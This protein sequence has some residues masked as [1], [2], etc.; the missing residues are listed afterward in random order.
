MVKQKQRLSGPNYCSQTIFYGNKLFIRIGI[1]LK[2]YQKNKRKQKPTKIYLV[3][4]MI[5]TNSGNKEAPPTKKPSILGQV[6]N[7]L[8]LLALTEPP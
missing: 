8:A 3:T 7:V 1:M 2:Q 6:I 5:S 4:F